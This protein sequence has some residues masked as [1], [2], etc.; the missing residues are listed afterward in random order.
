[1]AS[2]KA[3]LRSSPFLSGCHA[4]ACVGMF[5]RLRHRDVPHDD[6]CR[7]SFPLTGMLTLF[8]SMAPQFPDALKYVLRG[9]QLVPP[10]YEAKQ[11][12]VSHS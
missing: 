10:L 6:R 3:Y 8:V 5:G 1:M 12:G 9:F 11:R 4:H 7:K 2:N